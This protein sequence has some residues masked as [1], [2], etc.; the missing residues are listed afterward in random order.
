MAH[1]QAMLDTHPRSFE[2]DPSRLAET[3]DTLTDCASTC[4]LCA[5][6]CLSEEDVG[7]LAQC[8]RLNLDCADVCAATARVVSRQSGFDAALG[9][10]LVEACIAACRRCGDECSGHAEHMAHCA[11]C[12]EQCR[13]CEEACRGLL[14]EL[15]VA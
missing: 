8:I 12:A 1:A 7:R 13:R 14:D 10:P 2:V 5:D 3:I 4:T 6:A 9:R 11:V 15:R